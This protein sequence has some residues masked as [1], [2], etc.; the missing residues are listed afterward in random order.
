M[1][2]GAVLPFL[3]NRLTSGIEELVMAICLWLEE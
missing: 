3:K 1:V 2:K